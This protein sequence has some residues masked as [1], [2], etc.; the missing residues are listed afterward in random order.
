LGIVLYELLSGKLPFSAD[1][2]QA[3]IYRI[4]NEVPKPVSAHQP[5]IP[6]NLQSILA[7]CLEKDRDKR[8][9]SIEELLSDLRSLH[10]SDNVPGQAYAGTAGF[11]KL[12]KPVVWIPSFITLTFLVISLVWL[13]GSSPVLPFEERDW[14]SDYGF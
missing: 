1:Y 3:V 2:D 5:D 9:Q 4:L 12:A 11:K 13:L 7:Q 14:V 10:K 8:Y 6:E